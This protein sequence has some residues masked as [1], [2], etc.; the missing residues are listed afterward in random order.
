MPKKTSYD[1]APVT[2]PQLSVVDVATSVA[3]AAGEE[4]D[5]A[6]GVVHVELLQLIHMGADQ[7]LLPSACTA[8]T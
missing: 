6:A 7:M 1:A 4:S 8:T 3:P 5:G 2:A